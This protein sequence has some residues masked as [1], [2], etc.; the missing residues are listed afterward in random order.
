MTKLKTPLIW[1]R[2]TI[3]GKKIVETHELKKL[4]CKLNKNE[5]RSIRYL[6]EH[7][8]IYRIFR[9][10]FY[11]K[12]PNERENNY[13][14][15]SIFEIITLALKVKGIKN[16]YFGLETALKFND[17]THEY[18]TINYVITDL[19]RTTKVISILDS[20][21]QFYKWSKRYFKCGII[22][23][24]GLRYSD[25]ERTVLDRAYKRYL[26]NKSKEDMISLISEYIRSIDK[27]KLRDY[28]EH[29][30]KEF[31]ETIGGHL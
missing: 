9:G 6:Q 13:F 21:F 14:E 1:K 5:E 26:K 12:S 15:R 18:F 10:I 29:Y 3:E 27:K 25:K 31:R 8:Y 11:I 28:L 19:Y 17:M 30:P 2:L 20:K 24:N 4:A 7:H 23:K 16:W 22:K